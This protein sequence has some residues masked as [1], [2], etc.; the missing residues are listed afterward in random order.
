[1]AR[2]ARDPGALDWFTRPSSTSTGTLNLAY[3]ALDRHVVRGLA[4][5]AAL[6]DPFAEQ[7][8]RTSYSY[9]DLL[10][11]VGQLGGAFRELGVT[12]GRY[13]LLA[14]P[15]GPELLFGLL[16]CARL[17][18]VAVPLV[19][20][21]P[22]DVR[23][24]GNDPATAPPTVVVVDGERRAALDPVLEEVGMTPTYEVVRHPAPGTVDATLGSFD[25]AVLMRPGSFQ[26][27][28]CAELAPGSP[29]LVRSSTQDAAEPP[30]VFDQL[31][32]A[33]LADTAVRAGWAPGS[34]VAPAD[35]PTDAAP[36]A[37]LLAPLMLGAAVELR[38]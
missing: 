13:V 17:G 5:E 35:D 15:L 7:G 33:D 27:A 12:P 34:Y 11:Q 24:L 16:A 38:R 3:N 4:D 37:A 29:F 18:A 32:A 22:A 1:M 2:P 31:W 30:R 36:Y 10:E 25:L 21:E 19:D 8:S 26:P 28:A 23:R 9:A 14:L 20:A 6:L